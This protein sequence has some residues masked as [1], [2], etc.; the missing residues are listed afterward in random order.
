M[1]ASGLCLGDA[2]LHALNDKRAFKLRKSADHLQ[3][4]PPARRGGVDARIAQTD[5]AHAAAAQIVENSQQILQAAAQA[6]EFPHHDEIDF[7]R[8]AIGKHSIKRR[9]TGFLAAD[10]VVAV[11]GGDRP[12][13]L[14]GDGAQF[15]ELQLGVLAFADGGDAGVEGN[16]W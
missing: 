1:D 8:A 3:H 13:A 16:S 10:A 12:T 14:R 2:S 4:Q 9:S 15:A 5:K 7:A 11:F 6:I